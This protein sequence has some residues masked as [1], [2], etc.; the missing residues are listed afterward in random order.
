MNKI[1]RLILINVCLNFCFSLYGQEIQN[2]LV[3]DP[4]LIKEDTLYHLFCTGWG[5]SKFYSKDLINWTKDKAVFENP[6]AWAVE[7]V[8]GF[9]GHIWAP[10][11]CFHK[12]RYYLFYSISTFGKNNS[13]IG[14]A[15]NQTLNS[16]SPMYKWIDHGMVV[17][18]VKCRDFWNAIDPALVFDQDSIPWL[19]FGS[20]WGG[21]KLVKLR[22]DLLGV[23]TPEEWYTI[24]KRPRK[25]EINDS[26][27][28]DGAVEAPF[29]I[30]KNGNYYLFVSFD[31]CCRGVNSDYKIAVGRSKNVYGPY[32]DKDGESMDKGGGSI[33]LKGN[34]RW[35]GVGH[36]A[37]F[38]D[39]NIDYLIFHG[40][41][42]ND[43]GKP[44]LLIKKINWVDEWPVV[45]ID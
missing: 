18:S 22:N 25:F 36:C 1:C 29:I 16:N 26:L 34:E 13:C 11:I 17:Q 30:R 28:G 8:I 7:K 45:T 5:I 23:A 9:K 43:N 33:V 39:G 10:D 15:S 21:I 37:F 44:K 42:K 14:V 24:A 32:I 31:Y 19:A 35:S 40:Y 20:F 41:D 4:V 38:T 12:G 3:H 27:P 2:I 6:P